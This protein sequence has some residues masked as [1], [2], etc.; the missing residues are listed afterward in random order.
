[1]YDFKLLLVF[2]LLTTPRVLLL[3]FCGQLGDPVVERIRNPRPK[4]PTTPA[5]AFGKYFTD[6]MYLA[7]FIDG[8]WAR[9]RILP[10]QNFSLHPAAK[11]LHYA[12]E[13]CILFSI[14]EFFLVLWECSL[15]WF[16]SD[17]IIALIFYLRSLGFLLLRLKL[18]EW[19][20]HEIIDLRLNVNKFFLCC[21]SLTRSCNTVL[22]ILRLFSNFLHSRSKAW[23]HFAERTAAFVAFVGRRTW[24]ACS[25]RLTESHSRWESTFIIAYAV[26]CQIVDINRRMFTPLLFFHWISTAIHFCFWTRFPKSS[27]IC[28]IVDFHLVYYSYF[29]WTFFRVCQSIFNWSMVFIMSALQ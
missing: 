23:R 9:P 29:I 18:V 4:P 11:V 3:L 5:L 7:E 21:P 1:M 2:G 17:C 25:A 20:W 22:V 16:A 15:T 13:V 26:N 8:A 27:L 6:H 28:E 24:S 10:M 12:Q 14:L 19:E